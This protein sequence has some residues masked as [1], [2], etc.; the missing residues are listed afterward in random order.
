[1]QAA[2]RFAELPA[3]IG[4]GGHGERLT[5]SELAQRLQSLAG[6]LRQ[7]G[8][9]SA[10]RVAL[11]AENR[12][13]WAISYLAIQ[14]AGAT[15]IPLD[16]LQKSHERLALFEEAPPV[17]LII[18]AKF[19]AEMSEA[20]AQ[21]FPQIK[22][23]SMDGPVEGGWAIS[24]LYESEP[25]SAES[26]DP[27]QPASLIFTSGTTGKPKAVILTHRNITSNIN[28][29]FTAL[30]F[31]RT[32]RFL[33]VLPLAHV[34]E[35]TTGFLT[36]LMAGSSIYYA[37]SLAGPS[38]VEDLRYNDITI[39]VGVPLLY[40]KMV[41]A[42]RRKVDACS[43][44]QRAAFH[45]TYGISKV[46]LKFGARPGSLL[47]ASLREK[48]GMNHLRFMVSGGAPLD[49][50]IAQFFE[51]IGITF[52]QGYGMTECSPVMSLNSPDRNVIGSVGFA[53]P[54]L[55]L[56]IDQPNSEG[57]GEVMGRGDSV[58]PGYLNDPEKTAEILRDGWLATGD[59]GKLVDGQLYI[60][61]RAK[62]LIVSGAGKNIYPEEIETKLLESD[63]IGEALVLGRAKADKHG[64]DV[65]ALI[66]PDPELGPGIV[67]G[68]DP[69]NPASYSSEEL[70]NAIDVAVNEANS[71]LSDYKRITNWEIVEQ[72]FEKTS[73]R[74]IKRRL[75]S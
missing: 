40:E 24:K 37:R 20:L 6:G 19:Y 27:D 63:L 42:M 2:E 59:L 48:A 16:V 71:H 62:N 7:L 11:L 75:Y 31:S 34:Y 54:G 68:F 65:C 25:Y 18:S 49:P 9:G 52:I 28:G 44:A 22:I 17:A 3:L 23:I 30:Q 72:E 74:K 50:E 67:S 21:R 33:S 60:R 61:G 32:D 39:L 26:I 29:I 53:L 1:M 4:A 73:S 64:E 10:D 69:D 46:G 13:E 58:T 36:P 43:A 35:C 8:I 57:V 55:E 70:R 45:L 47:F 51:T 15:V 5:Y 66:Y 12:A 38:L 14:N 41:K 56:R